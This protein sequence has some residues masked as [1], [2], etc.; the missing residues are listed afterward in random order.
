MCL[1]Y[2][3]FFFGVFD[4]VYKCMTYTD[5]SLGTTLQ[6]EGSYA[7][8]EDSSFVYPPNLASPLQVHTSSIGELRPNNVYFT[9]PLL[10]SLFNLFDSDCIH[11]VYSNWMRVTWSC[12]SSLMLVM[13]HPIM[14]TNLASLLFRYYIHS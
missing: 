7:P 9:V 6:M 3:M 4:F 10:C 1:G 12:R 2:H 11:L 5:F 8:W 14:E 13:E